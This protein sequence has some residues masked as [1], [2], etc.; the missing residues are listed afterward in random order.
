[1]VGGRRWALGVFSGVSRSLPSFGKGSKSFAASRFPR[2]SKN[3]GFLVEAGADKPVV[4]QGA[5]ARGMVQ[6]A[7]AGCAPAAGPGE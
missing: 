6:G 1:M 4:V 5:K 7:G 2:V 3:A